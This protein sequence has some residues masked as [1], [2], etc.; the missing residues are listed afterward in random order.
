MEFKVGDRVRPYVSEY[1]RLDEQLINVE[2]PFFNAVKNELIG[3]VV[4]VCAMGSYPIEVEWGED[5]NSRSSYFTEDGVLL[6]NLGPD[7]AGISLVGSSKKFSLEKF[8]NL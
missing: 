4:R 5:G 8:V 7:M 1:L 3:V 2:A 6:M